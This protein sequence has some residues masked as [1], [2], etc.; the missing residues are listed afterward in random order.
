[1]APRK[2]DPAVSEDEVTDQGNDEAI[3]EERLSMS[4]AGAII[5]SIKNPAGMSTVSQLNFC[6][7]ANPIGKAS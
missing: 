1:M 4:A 6:Q 7:C 2:L 3:R 5:I